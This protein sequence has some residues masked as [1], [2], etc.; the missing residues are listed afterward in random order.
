MLGITSMGGMQLSTNGLIGFSPIPYDG[1]LFV[2]KLYEYNQIDSKVF[3]FSIG[4]EDEISYM[5]IGGVD[6]SFYI[7]DTL[8]WHTL[9]DDSHWSV[10]LNSV[11]LGNY[12]VST[13]TNTAVLD[14]GTSYILAPFEDYLEIARVFSLHSTC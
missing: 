9:P 7:A 14:T 2:D 13:T 11:S 8:T 10:S 4:A 5:T 3:S 12:S 6:E 1:D